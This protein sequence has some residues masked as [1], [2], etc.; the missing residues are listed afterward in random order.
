MPTRR[1]RQPR[2]ESPGERRAKQQPTE[3]GKGKITPVPEK[4][5]EGRDHLRS[6]A[7]A[8]QRRR[9]TST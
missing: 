4:I 5:G 9:R 6:R 3:A 2:P 8:F 7:E 1:P